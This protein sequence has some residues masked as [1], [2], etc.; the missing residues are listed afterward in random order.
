MLNKI[1][2]NTLWF[3]CGEYATPSPNNEGA[4]E[5]THVDHCTGLGDIARRRASRYRH[6]NGHLNQ[7]NKRPNNRRFLHRGMT[8]TFCNV[9]TGP[10]TSGYGSS[11]VFGSSSASGSSGVA[12]SDTSSTPPCPEFL[13]VNDLCT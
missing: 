3:D 1:N 8:A 5:E 10:N 13:S 9:P 7:N 6:N 4:H 12:S 2:G 11:G